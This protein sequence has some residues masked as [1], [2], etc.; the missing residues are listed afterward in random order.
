MNKGLIGV[1]ISCAAV[2]T[3]LAGQTTSPEKIE[4]YQSAYQ[5]A[6]KDGIINEDERA[7]LDTLASTLDLSSEEIA[8]IEPTVDEMRP[9]ALDQSGRWPLVAQNMIYGLSIYGWMVPYV[10][11]AEDTKWFVG[12]EMISLGAAYYLTYR[13]TRGMDIPHARAQMM[14]V[15]SAIGLR[16]GFGINEL[17]DLDADEGKLW[18][19]I[20]MG[21]VPVGIYVGD[22]LFNRWRPSNGQAWSLT[23]WAEIG[24]Y[25]MRQL[26]HMLEKEPENPYSD[27]FRDQEQETEKHEEWE[28]EHKPWNK[29][30]TLFDMAG[31]PVGAYVAHKF[32]GKRQ[33]TFGDAM[34]LLQGRGLGLFYAVLIGDMFNV[35]L[36]G[37]GGRI[38]R[39]GGTVAGTL[40]FD[41]FIEG[42][43][44]TFGEA[45]L[46]ALGTISGMGFTLGTAIILE[47]EDEKKVLYSLVMAGGAA[48]LY[49]ARSIWTLTPESRTETRH[50]GPNLSVYPSIR[51]LKVDGQTTSR[52]IIPTVNLAVVF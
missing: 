31:Y 41:K 29:V 44:Y 10:L 9:A 6:I 16:Y 33:Y 8:E 24:G 17:L 34:M 39:M 14:R 19:W 5:T 23:L 36:E 1:W 20:V 52:Q 15:G 51:L 30:H 50:H 45:A 26:H 22:N 37:T 18:S 49:L 3:S 35:D 27:R 7:I 40:L 32:F 38:L 4:I 2:T 11:D 21:S 25:T 46:T 42:Y 28:K 47:F 43:D 48:G 12:S 13:Y